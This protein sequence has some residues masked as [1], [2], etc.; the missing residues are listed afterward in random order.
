MAHEAL[1]ASEEAGNVMR[2]TTRAGAARGQEGIALVLAILVLM[3]LTFLGL[4][5]ALTTSTEFQIATN[6]RWSQQA[7]YNAE[8]GLEVAKRY[9][10]NV[11]GW[12]V[13]L[14][15]AQALV[16]PGSPSGVPA[17]YCLDANYMA[18]GP[19]GEPTRTCE[20]TSCDTVGNAGYGIVLWDKTFTTPFQ[21][22][23]SF[24]LNAAAP[25]VGFV[26]GSFTVWAR[27][28]LERDGAGNLIERQANDRL[29]LTVEGT[30]PA[31]GLST[32][33]V[34]NRAVRYIE[35]LLDRLEP[36]DCENRTGQI[37]AGAS[38]ANFDQCDPVTAG[39]ILGGVGVTEELPGQN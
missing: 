17:P 26:N 39:G 33:S 24:F 8:A 15:P 9:L 38:G 3:L 13:F 12:A 11:S 35:V 2:K 30:A 29:V 28:P 36:T 20:L 18:P 23:P 7:L 16:V 5:L 27:R 25:G 32:F 4:T 21:N 37:G 1:K 19:Y 22:F 10:R 34:A 31:A 6:Y 14:P